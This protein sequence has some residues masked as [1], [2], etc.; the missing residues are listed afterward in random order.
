MASNVDLRGQGNRHHHTAQTSYLDETFIVGT[1]LTTTPGQPTGTVIPATGT[2]NFQIGNLP[3][4]ARIL[5]A[6]L[7]TGTAVAGGTAT[8]QLGTT[9][10]GNNLSAT[11]VLG[12]AGLVS[13]GLSAT[14]ALYVNTEQTAVWAQIVVTGTLTA[15]QSDLIVEYAVVHGPT[16]QF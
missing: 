9:S 1:A 11:A 14:T 13:I 16:S 12:T 10:G 6:T 5:R 8:I 7:V 2:S 4:G 3:A 15:V